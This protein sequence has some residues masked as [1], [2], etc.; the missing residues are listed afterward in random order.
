LDTVTEEEY[1][2]CPACGGPLKPGQGFV[3]RWVKG[4]LAGVEH[5]LCPSDEIKRIEESE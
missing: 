3:Q 5:A 2:R 4:R 1:P